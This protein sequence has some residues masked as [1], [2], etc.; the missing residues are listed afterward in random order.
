MTMRPTGPF[1]TMLLSSAPSDV[2]PQYPGTH[3]L[4]TDFKHHAPSVTRLNHGSFGAAPAP[5]VQTWRDFQ[6]LWLTNPDALFFAK[7]EDSLFGRLKKAKESVLP[8]LRSEGDDH[9][10]TPLDPEQVALLD[11]AA[12]ATAVVA[13]HWRGLADRWWR[14]QRAEQLLQTKQLLQRER[15]GPPSPEVQSETG[16]PEEPEAVMD[17]GAKGSPFG[18]APAAGPRPVVF[19][20][21]VAY[22]ASVLCYEDYLGK[23]GLADLV[24][25]EVVGDHEADS[26]TGRTVRRFPQTGAELFENFQR[27]LKTAAAPYLSA[28]DATPPPPVFFM[29]DAVS[30]QPAF[31][32][33]VARMVRFFR[34][35]FSTA[36]TSK[37]PRRVVQTAVDGAH[38]LG[39]W[40]EDPDT[41]GSFFDVRTS[42]S[43]PDFFFSNMHKWA[44]GVPTS[45]VFYT[46]TPALMQQLVHVVPSWNSRHA[47]GLA[48]SS[49][50]EGTKDFSARLSVPQSVQYLQTWRSSNNETSFQYSHRLVLAARD[51]LSDLWNTKTEYYPADEL[52]GTMAMVKLPFVSEP[53]GPVAAAEGVRSL[54]EEL[55]EDFNIEAGVVHFPKMGG[56]YV[57]LSFAVYNVWEDVVRFGEAVLAVGE[58]RERDRAEGEK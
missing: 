12:T 22:G 35:T 30:S 48:Q 5:V 23:T 46:R 55:R 58:R 34:E 38:C 49:L 53:D 1:T 56:T 8:L 39:G 14:E 29:V 2:A 15:D 24:K 50:W 21:D 7:G 52:C 10:R 9:A 40:G 25:L 44:F 37:L 32:L 33:P 3:S 17:G 4:A 36:T 28:A 43:D 6:D 26:A 20:L 19:Y 54:R 18:A 16:E 13:G 57:R 45:T 11:N 51:Y 31:K 42:L 41:P 27:S 47:T